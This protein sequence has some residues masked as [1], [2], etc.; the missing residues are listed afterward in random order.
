MPNLKVATIIGKWYVGDV[1]L[2]PIGR[3]CVMDL[4]FGKSWRCLFR[5]FQ[6]I[7]RANAEGFVFHKTGLISS[8]SDVYKVGGEIK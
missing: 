8:G 5:G 6:P 2:T 7:I 4:N 3:H 1:A